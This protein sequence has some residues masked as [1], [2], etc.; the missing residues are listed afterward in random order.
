MSNRIT[1]EERIAKFRLE[2]L[3]FFQKDYLQNSDMP[4]LIS[5]DKKVGIEVVSAIPQEWAQTNSKVNKH[6]GK[7][8]DGNIVKSNIE[9]DCKY[10]FKG[11]IEVW[12]NCAVYFKQKGMFDTNIY[13]NCIL[14][15]IENK[16]RKAESHIKTDDLELYIFT[17]TSNINSND[18]SNVLTISQMQEGL[19]VFNTLYFDCIDRLYF[20]NS[21]NINEYK[22]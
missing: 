12:D 3:G 11:E 19:K 15:V 22:L 21:M 10:G 14:E 4:D 18:I 2:K 6:F 13:I 17:N 1:E 9:K 8:L 20:V 5:D 16:I 7:N